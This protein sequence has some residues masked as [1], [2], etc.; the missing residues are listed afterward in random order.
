MC[1]EQIHT[2]QFT[3]NF[4]NQPGCILHKGNLWSKHGDIFALLR[5]ILDALAYVHSLNIIHRDLN[6][7][8]IFLDSEGHI[9]IG[10]FGLA[11]NKDTKYD[12]R[13]MGGRV[14]SASSLG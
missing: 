6:P 8:N 13:D 2:P 4:N 9:K 5:Q 3:T 1:N 10:D 14:S 12:D 7:A 11:R